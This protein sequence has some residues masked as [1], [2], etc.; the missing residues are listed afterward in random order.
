MLVESMQSLNDN[1]VQPSEHL[2][3]NARATSPSDSLA[4]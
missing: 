1:E 2:S 4:S 3:K